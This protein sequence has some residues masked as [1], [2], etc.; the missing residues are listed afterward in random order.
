MTIDFTNI[1]IV[2]RGKRS[3]GLSLE[4]GRG[5]Y[6]GAKLRMPPWPCYRCVLLRPTGDLLCVCPLA[7]IASL[8]VSRASCFGSVCCYVYLHSAL[9]TLRCVM[10]ARRPVLIG[11]TL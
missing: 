5:G 1:V 2:S 3:V 7:W 9:R 6:R 8:V 11:Y 10:F 4:R